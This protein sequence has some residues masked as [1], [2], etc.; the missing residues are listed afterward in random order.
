M[1]LLDWTVPH[2]VQGKSLTPLLRGGEYHAREAIYGEIG[3]EG[4]PYDPTAC[5][6]YPEGPLTPDFTPRSKNAGC[7][8]IKSVRTR[9][10]KLVHYPGQLYGELYDLDTDPWELYNLFGHERS[11]LGPPLCLSR[12][13]VRSVAQSIPQKVQRKHSHDDRQCRHQQPGRTVDC[14]HVLS[15]F[16]EDAPT[17]ER[18][19]Q[20]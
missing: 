1:D 19:T 13:R 14:S 5:T 17:D 15:I 2:G 11:S 3:L 4:R 10:W 12:V 20:P 9:H 6:V 7:G 8:Q 16:W 18:R